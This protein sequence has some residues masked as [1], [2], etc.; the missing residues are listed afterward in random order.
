MEYANHLNE[1]IP[2]P[3]AEELAKL[4]STCGDVEK[5]LQGTRRHILTEESPAFDYLRP[6]WKPLPAMVGNGVDFEVQTGVISP[7]AALTLF[8]GIDPADAGALN[9]L[10]NDVP[11]EKCTGNARAHVLKNPEID[12]NSIQAFRAPAAACRGIT[13]TIRITADQQTEIF[14]L[15]LMVEE[16]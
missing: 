15:E 11:C 5:C 8:L 1:Y 12:P 2:A 16:K 7:N 3:T 14:Y 9:V 6:H 10:V 13:Q 4:W